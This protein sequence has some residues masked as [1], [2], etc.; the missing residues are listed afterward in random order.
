MPH[1][2]RDPINYDLCI[3]TGEM[4]SG[5]NREA[6]E[7]RDVIIGIV[8]PIDLL[9]YITDTKNRERKMAYQNGTAHSSESK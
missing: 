9:N 1:A 2:Y 6:V 5:T 3:S 4:I 8:T 7:S